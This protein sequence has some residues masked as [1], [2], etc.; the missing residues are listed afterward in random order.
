[1]SYSFKSIVD[2]GADTD[3]IYYNAQLI[4]TQTAD[5]Q[6][7]GVASPIR[8]N[9]TRDSA[10]VKDASQYY[11]SIVRFS[12]NG[13]GKNLPLF[14]P[15]IQ[16][17]GYTS[18]IQSDPNLTIY[19]LSL[20]YQRRWNYTDLAGAAQTVVI[21]V[22]PSSNP[23]RY[24][25]ET[26]NEGAA[27]RPSVPAGGIT[28][29]D[30][31]T[32]S[33]WVYSYKHWTTLVKNTL[34]TAMFDLWTDFNVKWAAIPNKGVGQ[35][36][37]YPTF[38]DFLLAHDVPFVKYDEVTG[39]FEIYGDTRAFNVSGQ[40]QSASLF[41]IDNGTQPAIPAFVP[42]PYVATNPPSPASDVYIRLFF[43]DN[44]FGLMNNFNNT[45]LGANNTS[46]ILFPLT[47]GPVRLSAAIPSISPIVYTNEILFT[48]QQYQNILNNNPGLQ[49][50]PSAPPP[51]YNPYFL[52]PVG[53]QNLYWKAVQD[54]P[55][56][57]SLWSPVSAIVF[58]S[59][60]LPLKKEFSAVP[61]ALG[62]TNTIGTT[63]SPAAFDPVISD[64]VLDEN[65]AKAQGWRDF[66]LYEPSAEYRMV[67]MNASHEEVRNIDIQVFWK[68]RLT[69]ELIPL[70]MFNCS[71]VSIKMMFRKIDYR[72]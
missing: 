37:P 57:G 21:T 13:P 1:M 28:K 25:S 18:P 58:T 17:N 20:A 19:Y 43:N 30:I 32:R 67:S 55:S 39:L 5:L 6:T 64:F 9:E 8:F 66:V 70:S 41:P 45:Y 54:Y 34:Q 22:T 72:S 62:Q 53:K 4:A 51:S 63:N 26:Q 65:N 23:I 56:T 49:N 2:G 14:I 48:N 35:T 52:I 11:F 68:Y 31:S 36:T 10:I 47:V 24:I 3:L 50:V 38:N 46:S 69:G 60:L 71:D 12:M 44:L 29:Q 7:S 61:I 15:L 33:Y 42:T 27:P 16:T 40:I 59:A